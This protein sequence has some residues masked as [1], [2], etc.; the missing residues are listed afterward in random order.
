M[1]R[2]AIVEDEKEH[3]RLIRDYLDR[4]SRE[5]SVSFQIGEFTDGLDIASEYKAEYDIIFLDIQMKHMD[6]MTAAAKIREL[7]EEVA[8]IFITSTVQF[9]VQGYL[10]D[11]LGYVL[12]P[13]PY[14]AFAQVLGKAVKKIQARQ[15]VFTITI[16]T[17]SGQLKMDSVQIYYIESQKHSVIVHSSK[18]EYR[19][20]G[21]L[22]RFEE[23]LEP[24]GFSK[25]HNAYLINLDYADAILS[26][27]IRLSTGEEIPVSRARKKPFMDALTDHIGG[28]H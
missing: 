19:T 28:F 22:K 9:A 16:D 20:A 23:M 15:S 4:Y 18:G 17:S 2:I 12:K 14:L 8:L 5:H 1:I 6:G 21:P 26:A 11:A 7:D 27:S 24:H 13:V 10:V 25:C 3:L